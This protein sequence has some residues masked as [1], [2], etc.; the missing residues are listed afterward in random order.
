MA[1]LS[2][3]LNIFSSVGFAGLTVFMIFPSFSLILNDLSITSIYGLSED[4]S[5]VASPDFPYDLITF[6]FAYSEIGAAS[7]FNLRV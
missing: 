1:P 6:C 2:L 5:L 3:S 7:P 4:A